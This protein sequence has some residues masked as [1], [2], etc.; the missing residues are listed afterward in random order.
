M[1]LLIISILLRSENS[2]KL[3]ANIA[4]SSGTIVAVEITISNFLELSAVITPTML[5]LNYLRTD[6][7]VHAQIFRAGNT[8]S[9]PP[10][11]S[12]AR[13]KQLCDP[14]YGQHISS[15]WFTINADI[16]NPQRKNV[17]HL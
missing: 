2:F 6:M 1:F 5:R 17:L 16:N 4:D 10:R 12:F 7:R 13:V 8:P 11:Y 3:T 9:I 15:T 14:I